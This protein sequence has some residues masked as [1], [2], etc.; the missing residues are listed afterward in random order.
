[1]TCI[2]YII[3]EVF[4]L[5]NFEIAVKNKKNKVISYIFLS[6]AMLPLL[7]LIILR[8]TNVGTDF[9]RYIELYLRVDNDNVT[10]TDQA[11]VGNIFL[12]I[13]KAFTF[14][15]GRNYRIFFGVIGFFT[16]FFLFK[17]IFEESDKPTLSLFIFFS[18]CLYYQ[19]FNQFRQMLAISLILYAYKFYKSKNLKAY[20][21]I[22]LC[23]TV[24][25]TSAIIM[26]PFYWIGDRDINKKN[27]MLYILFGIFVLF[28]YNIIEVILEKTAYG[29][30]YMKYDMYNMSFSISSIINLCVR[31]VMLISCL[32][33]YKKLINRDSD[34]KFLYNMAFFCTIF[35]ILTLKSYVFGRLTTYFFVYYIFL[36]PKVLNQFKGKNKVIV[37]LILILGFSAYQYIYY[38]SDNGAISGGYNEYKFL[39]EWRYR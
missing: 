2:I 37:L 20:I 39:T 36:I 25:H 26:L 33:F 27:I 38:I 19:C 32:L 3:I 5:C 28:G 4:A 1:M 6:I 9:L 8:D 29:K 31:I 10:S 7:F 34:N 14:F 17:S 12:N 11:W 35:Q 24:M 21:I 22:V 18:F 16:L 13:M 23:A 30:I 15:F